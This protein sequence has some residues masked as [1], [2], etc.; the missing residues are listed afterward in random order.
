[1]SGRRVGS[2]ALS[3]EVQGQFSE[4]G[5]RFWASCLDIVRGL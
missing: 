3:S 5:F 2:K 1:M 4:R